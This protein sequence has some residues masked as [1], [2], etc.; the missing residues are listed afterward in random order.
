MEQ[1]QQ[2]NFEIVS[3]GIN[4][5]PDEVFDY[6]ANGKN[7]P[8]WTN[9]FK[10]VDETSAI[11]VT[12]QGELKVSME[13]VLNKKLGVIDTI[14]EMPDGSKNHSWSRVTGNKLGNESVFSFTLT[15]PPLPLDALAKFLAGQKAQLEEEL[16]TLKS[17][18]EN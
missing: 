1:V 5:S 17:I 3:I 14:I 2:K 9:F 4:A 12:S 18:L 16:R 8:E 6:V 10:E 15:A 7:L 11:I 13:S